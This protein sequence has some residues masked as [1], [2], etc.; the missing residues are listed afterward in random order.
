LTQLAA[1][2]RQRFSIPVIAVTGS[3]G[4]TTVKEMIAAI[5]AAAYGE[6]GRLATQGNLNNDIGV[7]VTLLR[8]NEQHRAA[9][10]ELGM[11]HPG[12]IAELAQITQPTVA[13]VNNAQ[14]EHQ[15]FMHSIEA[16]AKENGSVFSALPDSGVAVF[17]AGSTYD[18]LWRDLARNRKVLTFGLTEVA[19]VYVQASGAGALRLSLAGE[20][21]PAI[22]PL[23]ILG[24]HN[25]LNAAAAAACA[26]AAG[27]SAE[28]IAQGLAAFKPVSGRLVVKHLRHGAVLVDDTYN[29]NPD[30]VRAAIEVLASL[31]AP[32]LLVLGD[33]GEVGEQGPEFHAEVG[34]YAKQ[35]GI[36]RLITVGEASRHAAQGYG[37]GAQH[38]SSIAEVQSV[39]DQSE[40]AGSILVKGSRFMK[41][42]RLVAALSQSEEKNAA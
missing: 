21:W 37:V 10:I 27:V 31:S 20:S 17:A 3:N 23:Q 29:A 22:I 25:W 19:D 15:E 1:A 32:T 34:A 13:L 9:V 2:W 18:S 6:S 39:L 41:M 7:P 30:S 8:L 35:R 42:E 38:F 16:V 36:S 33:M 26:Y 11:N 24:A 14:R 4:K 28:A 40:L 5:L 12:E